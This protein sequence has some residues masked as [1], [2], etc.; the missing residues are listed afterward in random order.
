MVES[1]DFCVEVQE[2]SLL[3]SEADRKPRAAAM[4]KMYC[5]PGCDLPIN[6]PDH[7]VRKIEQNYEAA[8]SDL[9]DQVHHPHPPHTARTLPPDERR[10]A[11][12]LAGM[13]ACAHP[14]M[15]PLHG[16]TSSHR[17]CVVA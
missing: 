17:P 13:L 2:Y 11:A 8:A 16:A 12:G 9:F 15:R 6:I 5:E 7:M 3:F 4:W 1:V 14:A 10:G